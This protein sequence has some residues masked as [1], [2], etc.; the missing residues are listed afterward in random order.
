MTSTIGRRSLRLL[1]DHG[2]PAP[3]RRFLIR[4]EVSLAKDLGWA[5]YVDGRL[6]AAAE[7]AGFEAMVT[8]DKNI[9]YQQNLAER[10]IA[11]AVLPTNLWPDLLPH[12]SE[13]VAFIDGIGQGA[14]ASL[15]LPRRPLLRR[16]PP[17][18][19]L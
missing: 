14:Y 1:F 18:Q 2:V 4:H 12:I 11:L 3:L 6:I 7:T 16:P 19:S 5:E 9:G 13:V 15:D 10:R 17:S 8:C